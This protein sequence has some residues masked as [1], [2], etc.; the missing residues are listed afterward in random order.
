VNGHTEM[1][2]VTFGE[3]CAYDVLDS[4]LN[5]FSRNTSWKHEGVGY[6]WAARIWLKQGVIVTALWGSTSYVDGDDQ[7][8]LLAWSEEARDYCNPITVATD[9]IRKV[10]IL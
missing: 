10:E 4:I 8:T 1:P 6:G 2:T 7:T 3:N 9:D 5:S